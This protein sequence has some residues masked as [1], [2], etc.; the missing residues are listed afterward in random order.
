MRL[1][2]DRLQSPVASGQALQGLLR[3]KAPGAAVTGPDQAN[4]APAR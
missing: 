3:S 2:W 1:L 4:G